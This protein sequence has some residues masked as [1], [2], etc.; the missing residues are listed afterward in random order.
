MFACFSEIYQRINAKDFQLPI[1]SGFGYSLSKEI[2]DVDSNDFKD[3]AAG[4]PFGGSAVVLRSRPVVSFQ[5]Q[6]TLV[7]QGDID[8]KVKSKCLLSKCSSC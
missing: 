5:T 8:P 3:I 2:S 4:A 6:V 1:N 7:T